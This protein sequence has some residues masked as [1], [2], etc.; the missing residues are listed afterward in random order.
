MPLEPSLTAKVVTKTKHHCP[1]C[2]RVPNDRCETKGHVIRCPHHP[3]ELYRPG[4]ECISCKQV[5]IRQVEQEMEE[6]MERKRREEEEE[7]ERAAKK[8]SRKKDKWTKE[9]REEQRRQM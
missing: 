3:V 7:R 6:R 5:D 1:V 4:N 2:K 9:Q 8:K